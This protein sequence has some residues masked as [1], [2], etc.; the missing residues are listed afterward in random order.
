VGQNKRKVQVE[1]AIQLCPNAIAGFRKKTFL[2]QTIQ[3]FQ[4]VKFS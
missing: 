2:S 3:A 1:P 4:N